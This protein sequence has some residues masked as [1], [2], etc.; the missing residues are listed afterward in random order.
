LFSLESPEAQRA[1]HELELLAA[2]VGARERAARGLLVGSVSL[3]VLALGVAIVLELFVH[4]PELSR[5]T[6]RSRDA[7]AAGRLAWRK[8]ATCSQIPSVAVRRSWTSSSAESASNQSHRHFHT[9][10]PRRRAR[11]RAAR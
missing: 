4:R 8:C 11:R 2:K 1:R 10:A 3:S 7:L 9:R 6:Q 5:L